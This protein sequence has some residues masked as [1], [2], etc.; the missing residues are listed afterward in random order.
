MW[1]KLYVVGGGF[2]VTLYVSCQLILW[3]EPLDETLFA[4]ARARLQQRGCQIR[5]PREKRQFFNKYNSQMNI[6]GVCYA[7]VYLSE[8]TIHTDLWNDSMVVRMLLN[9]EEVSR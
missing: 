7:F 9:N 2:Y 3:G 6:Y 4:T 1:D 8:I 5:A